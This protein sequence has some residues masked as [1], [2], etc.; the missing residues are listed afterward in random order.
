MAEAQCGGCHEVGASGESRIPQ[1][2]AFRRLAA[3]HPGEQLQVVIAEGIATG[4]PSM[5]RW[6]FTDK[7]VG[8]LLAYVRSI[9][10]GDPDGRP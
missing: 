10:A 8:Q 1:A 2:P 9:P 4:H 7:E 3:Q 5:P 6:I